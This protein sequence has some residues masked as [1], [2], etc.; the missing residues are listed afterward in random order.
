MAKFHT[1]EALN[2]DISELK[3][4]T[5]RR[6]PAG[7]SAAG[8]LSDDGVAMEIYDGDVMIMSI[9]IGGMEQK[10]ALDKIEKE[11]EEL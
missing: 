1:N 4:E 5:N 10:D 8:M 6:L 2:L 7:Y 3:A 9:P 11:I